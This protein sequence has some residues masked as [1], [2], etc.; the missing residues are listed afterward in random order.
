V[1]CPDVECPAGCEKCSSSATCT[2][3]ATG[4]AK[5]TDSS[6]CLSEFSVFASYT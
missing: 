1:R 4:Y 6:A 3:C 5:R 2:H